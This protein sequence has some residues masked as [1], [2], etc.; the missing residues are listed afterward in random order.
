MPVSRLAK[1][2]LLPVMW[3]EAPVSNIQRCLESPF[4]AS[5]NTANTSCFFSSTGRSGFGVAAAARVDSG[6]AP[7]AGLVQVD[8]GEATAGPASSGEVAPCTAS[9]GGETAACA[10]GP[11]SEAAAGPSDPGGEAAASPSDPGGEAAAG[12]SDPGGE[13][14]AGAADLGGG[15]IAGAASSGGEVAPAPVS[16]G[17]A[18]V[19]AP[20]QATPA[21]A[22]VFIPSCSA[23]S[24]RLY[25][26]G[27]ANGASDPTLDANYT[28]ALR[29]QCKQAD[30][31]TLVDLDPPTPTVFDLDYYKQVS[32]QRGLLATDSALLLHDATKAY[33]LRQANATSSAEFFADFTES[34]INMSKI[35][36]LTHGHGE[37]RHKCSV[38][39]PPSPTT[40]SATSLAGSLLL[41][42]LLLGAAIAV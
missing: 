23:F 32:A 1:A 3:L 26:F 20:V 13:A 10:T 37:I 11:D 22:S 25:N 6:E 40:S 16:S 34:F 19:A 29:G 4:S 42:V 33:V 41:L 12:P 21:A 27:G 36:V 9:P 24:G 8:P 7:E 17:E 18:V 14:A 5:P 38:V 31:T 15:E 2:S 39:N 35:G 28:A 30:V